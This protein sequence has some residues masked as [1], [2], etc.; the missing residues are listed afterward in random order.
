M[1]KAICI[2]LLLC[3]VFTL[4]SVPTMAAGPASAWALPEG[5]PMFEP[6]FVM[7]LDFGTL[8]V[9][10]AGFAKKA[11]MFYSQNTISRSI[12]G[13][14]ETEITRNSLYFNAKDGFALFVVKGQLHVTSNDSLMAEALVPTLN[15]GTAEPIDMKL[16]PVVHIG[17]VEQ[18]V[19]DPGLTVDACLVCT[20]PNALYYGNADLL[21]EFAG[22]SLAFS[23]SALGSYVSMGFNELDGEPT[24]DVTVLIDE[25]LA[26]YKAR[27]A[28]QQTLPPEKQEAK[29]TEKPVEK[30]H[31]DEIIIEDARLEY[32][33][34]FDHYNLKAKL[35]DFFVEDEKTGP[36]YTCMLSAQLL[37]ANGD[38]TPISGSL[39]FHEFEFGQAVWNYSSP[40]INLAD[41]DGMSAVRFSGYE[42]SFDKKGVHNIRGRFSK[43]PV[44]TMEE[45]TNGTDSGTSSRPAAISVE[46]VSVSFTDLQPERIKD[47]VIYLPTL[48][49]GSGA[50]EKPVQELGDGLTYAVICFQITNLTKNE[51]KLADTSD[52]FMV[53]LNYDD[54]FLYSTADESE[55]I[56]LCG[57]DYA[58]LRGSS[59]TGQIMAPPLA[60]MNVTLYL[61][62]A[63]AVSTGTDKPLVVSFI[64]DFA[65]KQQIDVKIR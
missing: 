45:L 1:K 25:A 47:S 58:V 54:G 9:L 37:D 2:I 63:K 50:W 7:E 12:N 40:K 48:L 18:T 59:S 43:A 4:I 60:E 53:Q 10:D 36:I 14:K 20:V 34:T 26:A 28:E 44:F 57:D 29:P 49:P 30:Q 55:C 41:L 8:T 5:T 15:W 46:N 21:L 16:Y 22:A 19:L 51:W 3:A 39:C 24:E 32:D 11:E 23:K 61:P 31:L 38:A 27:Q 62:V 52:H 56:F 6:G 17:N 42:F 13:V 65:G 64:T 33:S 35:R